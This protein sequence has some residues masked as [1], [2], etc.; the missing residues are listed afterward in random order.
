MDTCYYTF[1]Q[2]HEMY[3]IKSEPEG[4]KYGLRVILLCQCRFINFKKCT[5][6]VE[7]ADS[8]EGTWRAEGTWEISV[9]SS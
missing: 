3:N 7:D 9:P 6:S 2:I 4:I 5:T 1:V 8:A